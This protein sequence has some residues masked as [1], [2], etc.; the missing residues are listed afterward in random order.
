MRKIGTLR[1]KWEKA[2]KEAGGHVEDFKLEAKAAKET[3]KSEVVKSGKK[4]SEKAVDTLLEMTGGSLSR[5][6]DELEKLIIFAGDQDQIREDHVRE[7]VVPSREWNVFKM[8]DAIIAGNA[9]EALRQLRI[10]IGSKAKADDVAIAQ[11]LPMIGRTLRLLWQ[12]RLCI[13]AGCS[14]SNP[15]AA[16]REQ[17]PEKPNLVAEQPY[18]QSSLMA[19]ARKVALPK[20]A[21]C[22]QILANADSRLKGSLPSF[23][24]I[25]TLE[26]MVLEMCGILAP[27]R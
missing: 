13:D 11:V 8:I 7:L 26:R 2:V 25:D 5:A 19:S 24:T 3:V 20:L 18:R 10:L 1:G 6:L 27:A 12:A 22:L 9:P 15:P 21:D 23:S 4:M 14:A 17:F 16:I